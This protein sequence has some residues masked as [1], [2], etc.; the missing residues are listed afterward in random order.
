M[1]MKVIVEQPFQASDLVRNAMTRLFSSTPRGFTE[2]QAAALNEYDG[3]I[4]SG[5]VSG[6][7]LDD[8]S[9]IHRK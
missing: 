3:P 6:E 4:Q 8:D 9:L 1:T 5:N 7:V 2:E